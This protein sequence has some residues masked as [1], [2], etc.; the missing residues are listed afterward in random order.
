MRKFWI[1]LYLLMNYILNENYTYISCILDI[2]VSPKMHS[3]KKFLFFYE[4]SATTLKF[5]SVKGWSYLNFRENACDS[6][7]SFFSPFSGWGCKNSTKSEMLRAI[8]YGN[9][10]Q[11]CIS[12]FIL[13]Q[14]SRDSWNISKNWFIYSYWIEG[15]SFQEYV[16][17]KETNALLK[18]CQ[19]HNFFINL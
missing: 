15:K 16:R 5:R 1:L 17:F 8:W 7:E 6:F 19:F 18:L 3:S 13:R 2:N 4:H 11:K 9:T 14:W 12:R 10:T